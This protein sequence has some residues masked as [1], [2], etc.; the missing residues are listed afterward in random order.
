MG[1]A[2][3]FA[4]LHPFLALTIYLLTVSSASLAQSR[5]PVESHILT[6][7]LAIPEGFAG[8]QITVANRGALAMSATLVLRD[9][10]GTELASVPVS[11]AAFDLHTIDLPSVLKGQS[12]SDV[13]SVSVSYTGMFR[14]IASQVALLRYKNGASVDATLYE[15]REFLSSKLNAVWWQPTG[16]QS[17]VTITNTSDSAQTATITI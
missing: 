12:I 16:S 4:V 14:T 13:R 8:A 7:P 5:L 6:T 15:D 3:R 11:L 1:F 2:L 9:G 10:A 17:F